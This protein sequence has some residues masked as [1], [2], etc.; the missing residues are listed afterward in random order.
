LGLL[1][2]GINQEIVGAAAAENTEYNKNMIRH[3]LQEMN[4]Q[5]LDFKLG[6]HMHERTFFGDEETVGPIVV[7]A[8]AGGRRRSIKKN[9]RRISRKRTLKNKNISRKYSKCR[10]RSR[11]CSRRRY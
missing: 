8:S 10:S 2:C 1:A 4:C 11:R 6:E 7:M 9:I 5:D 3:I